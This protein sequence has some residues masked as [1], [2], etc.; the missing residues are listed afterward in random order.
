MGEYV[1]IGPVHMWFERRGH[2]DP[3]VLLHGDLD[4]NAA[5]GNQLD[6]LAK[7]FSVFA[8]ERRGHGHTPDESA[9]APIIRDP[10]GNALVL[11]VA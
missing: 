2:A 10:A 3:L 11:A 9:E 7:H 5:W 8:P 6:A 4:T 1:D